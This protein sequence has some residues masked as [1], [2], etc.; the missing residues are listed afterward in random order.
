VVVRHLTSQGN[1]HEGQGKL[2]LCKFKLKRSKIKL[3]GQSPPSANKMPTI[4]RPPQNPEVKGR[5]TPQKI[6][7]KPRKRDSGG[8]KCKR[9]KSRKEEKNKRKGVGKEDGEEHHLSRR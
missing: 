9:Q 4:T 7:T 1:N 3:V 8:N 2:A 6:H 5:N